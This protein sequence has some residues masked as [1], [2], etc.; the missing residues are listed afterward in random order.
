LYIYD[1]NGSITR[2]YHLFFA[3]VTFT[4]W[5]SMYIYVPVFVTYLE[6]LGSS[7]AL[8]GLILGSYGMMQVL[9]RLPIGVIS[10]KMQVRKP[11]LIV[12]LLTG[13]ISCFGFALTE[14]LE[15][16]F[17]S[18]F[19]SGITASMWVAFTVLYASYFKKEDA[20]KAMGNI[21]FVT[22]AAQLTSMGLSG[23]LV[24]EWGWKAPFWLGGIVGLIGLIMTF[25]INDPKVNKQKEKIKAND[26]QSVLKEPIV[27]KAAFLSGI[28][29]AVLFI[30]MF[31]FSPTHAL[32]IGASK[33]SLTIFVFTFM[34]PHAAAS[35]ITGQYLAVRFNKWYILLVGFLGTA[36]FSAVIPFTQ[37][38]ELLYVTQ[39]FNGFF[40]GM[41]MPL[42]MGVAIQSISNNKRATAMG[43][44]QALYALGIFLGPFMA[45]TFSQHTGFASV[46]YLAG[47]LGL[48]GV[49]L[50]VLWYRKEAS[51]VL[52][53]KTNKQSV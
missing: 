40:Q 27:L 16:A 37:N 41:T 50:S 21:Q 20:T 23:Y 10:D 43:L 33:E 42:L 47:G 13:V 6:Y 2:F 44:Y 3:V 29:H 18:R 1:S 51:S 31:G 49:T 39:A 48:F 17:L 22:V 28:A 15:F 11:F 12:G 53:K 38:L 7:Y 8:I 30:T 34:I 36:L 25:W 4:Y 19:I 35:I 45:G 46:F 5:F 52:S 14:S 26:L 24:S 32:N 9:L